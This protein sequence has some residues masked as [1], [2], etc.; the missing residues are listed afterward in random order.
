MYPVPEGDLDGGGTG[1]NMSWP[2]L[3]QTP[4]LLRTGEG[5]VGGDGEI[6]GV[7]T[8]DVGEAISF[9]A[10]ASFRRKE[11]LML[12]RSKPIDPISNMGIDRR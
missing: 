4:D 7:I 8:E 2:K 11:K 10:D 6:G 9:H 12:L 3:L 5:L 1:K